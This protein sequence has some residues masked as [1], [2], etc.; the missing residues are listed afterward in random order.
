MPPRVPDEE[1]EL[2]QIN[3]SDHQYQEHRIARREGHPQRERDLQQIETGS[4]QADEFKVQMRLRKHEPK[5][6]VVGQKQTQAAADKGPLQQTNILPAD[7]KPFWSE[8]DSQ[9]DKHCRHDR[10]QWNRDQI[11][12][13]PVL[14]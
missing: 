11:R 4:E 1:R 5:L 10:Q 2:Q 6:R 7:I 12:R 14:S 8:E 3:A 9:Y 13:G